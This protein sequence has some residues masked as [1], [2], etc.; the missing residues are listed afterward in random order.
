MELHREGD[1]LSGIG[2]RLKH[3]HDEKINFVNLYI[4]V[5]QKG[6]SSLFI[7]GHIQPNHLRG[8]VLFVLY[9]L[10]RLTK[11]LVYLQCIL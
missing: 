10:Q 4:F 1:T 8:T 6:E 7:L 3:I 5:I 11:K 9:R 2:Y